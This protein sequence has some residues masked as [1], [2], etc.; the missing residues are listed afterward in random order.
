M[1]SFNPPSPPADRRVPIEKLSTAKRQ[2]LVACLASDGM[3]YRCNGAWASSG[4]S[5]IIC[6]I[7]VADLIRDG[8]LALSSND[9][10]SPAQL[11]PLGKWYAEAASQEVRHTPVVGTLTASSQDPKGL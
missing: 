4:T 8:L 2:A 1:G 6:G 7:T 11:T 10:R 9:R 5:D 3:L